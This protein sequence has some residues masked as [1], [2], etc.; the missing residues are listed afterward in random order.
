MADRY[1]LLGRKHAQA[2]IDRIP[3]VDRD[4]VYTILRCEHVQEDVEAMLEGSEF[5]G[6]EY[7][8]SLTDEQ[9]KDF[10]KNIAERYTFDG[11]YDCNYGYWDNLESLINTQIKIETERGMER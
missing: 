10:A 7:L 1:D 8:E 6:N 5:Q 9:F 11:K 4:M 3:Q 2:I